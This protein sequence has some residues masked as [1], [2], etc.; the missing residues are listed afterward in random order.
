[1]TRWWPVLAYAALILLVSSIPASSMPVS[2]TLWSLD[3]VMHCLEYAVLAALL[4][5]AL[6]AS[7][8]GLGPAALWAAAML[9]AALFG[10]VDEWYQSFTPGRLSS[11]YDALADAAGAVAGAALNGLWLVRRKGSQSHGHRS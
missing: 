1:M 9:G 8:P 6:A 2:Q 10:A 7:A 11:R 4:S 3:K 5:R